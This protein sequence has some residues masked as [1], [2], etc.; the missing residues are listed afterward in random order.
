MRKG[1]RTESYGLNCSQCALA[2][3][4]LS[5]CKGSLGPLRTCEDLPRNAPMGGSLRKSKSVPSPFY[6]LQ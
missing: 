4:K 6:A 3:G 1:M 5:P 2:D